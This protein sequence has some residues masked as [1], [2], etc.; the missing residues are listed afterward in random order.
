MILELRKR[1]CGKSQGRAFLAKRIACAKALRQ[2]RAS[3]V[4]G[5][6]SGLE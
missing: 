5:S 1:R 3:C 6:V 2:E 4:G